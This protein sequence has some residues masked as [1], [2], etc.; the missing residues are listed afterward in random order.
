MSMNFNDFTMW[1]RGD[2]KTMSVLLL[3]VTHYRG[4]CECSAFLQIMALTTASL[5]F[6]YYDKHHTEDDA[7]VCMFKYILFPSLLASQC[8][9]RAPVVPL[10][11]MINLWVFL[12]TLKF[13]CGCLRRQFSKLFM[14]LAICNVN[15]LLIIDIFVKTGK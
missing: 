10:L 4:Y 9:V 13:F 14:L 15:N 2:T 1:I 12:E 7:S 11:I 5:P 3:R 8:Y 6:E